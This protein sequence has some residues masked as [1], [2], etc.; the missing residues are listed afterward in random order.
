MKIIIWY[1]CL[2]M[3][4]QTQNDIIV[5]QISTPAETA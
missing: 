5:V 1:V 2:N 4:S 3:E